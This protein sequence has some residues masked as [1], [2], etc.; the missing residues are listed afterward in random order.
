[1]VLFESG[2]TKHRHSW[3][4]LVKGLKRPRE[5]VVNALKPFLLFG[6]SAGDG[7]KIALGGTGAACGK[8]IAGPADLAPVPL[9][10]AI[11]LVQ[12]SR[13]GDGFTGFAFVS[14]SS[15]QCGNTN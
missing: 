10:L 15:I 12:T 2:G 3:S 11:P 14:H 5:L 7:E 9:P 13:S 4:N 6:W 1:M 8:F